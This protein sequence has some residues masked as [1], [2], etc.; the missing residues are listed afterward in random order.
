MTPMDDLEQRVHAVL[1]VDGWESADLIKLVA[2]FARQEI[3]AAYERAAEV[4]DC[5]E[6]D[7]GNA[8]AAGIRL[9]KDIP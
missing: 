3:N 5:I 1:K 9:L 2:N 4:A 8:I 6:E 7:A